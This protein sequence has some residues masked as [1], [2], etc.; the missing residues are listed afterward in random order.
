[1]DHERG[2]ELVAMSEVLDAAPEILEFVRADLL[3]EGQDP[4][5][6]DRGVGRRR[7]TGGREGVSLR[8]S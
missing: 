5:E 7:R 4:N 6:P 8:A 2:R 3:D 1:M